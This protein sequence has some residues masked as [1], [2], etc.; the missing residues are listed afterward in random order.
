MFPWLNSAAER[1]ARYAAWCRG[2]GLVVG[3]FDTWF[4]ITESIS[5]LN[6]S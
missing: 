2:M 3:S 1:Y 4:D 5:E 6:F